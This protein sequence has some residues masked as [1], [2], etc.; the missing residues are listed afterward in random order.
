[1]SSKF[2]AKAS[3]LSSDESESS[4]E[5]SEKEEE[6]K[7]KVKKTVKKK[8]EEE[9]KHTPA[10]SANAKRYE[11]LLFVLK[12]LK[13]H[14]KNQDFGEILSDFDKFVEEI[15]KQGSNVATPSGEFL[16]FVVRALV[17]IEDCLNDLTAEGKKK[18]NKNNSQNYNKLKQK[19]KKYL[20]T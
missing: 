16:P 15:N 10:I 19:F 5:E 12:G 7:K 6:V 17:Q 1:M 2:F 8:P 11:T 9:F 20:T 18:L 13:N 14:I 4:S 3:E